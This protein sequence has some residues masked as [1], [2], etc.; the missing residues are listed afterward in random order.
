MTTP[1][2]HEASTSPDAAHRHL[3]DNVLQSAEEAVLTN[4]ASSAEALAPGAFASGEAFA[5]RQRLHRYQE[6]LAAYVARK[7]AQSALMA[8]AAG[9]AL[10]AL[11]R[12]A[13]SRRGH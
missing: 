11:V 13:F 12:A 1:S 2:L 6:E 3:G 9:A 4:P 5:R 10:A 8:L 7:P